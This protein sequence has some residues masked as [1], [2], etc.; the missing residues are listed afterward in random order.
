[1]TLYP[2]LLW[3]FRF[4]WAFSF[5]RWWWWRRWC[6]TSKDVFRCHVSRWVRRRQHLRDHYC[7]T[8]DPLRD[9]CIFHS[10]KGIHSK[11][12][13]QNTPRFFCTYALRSHSRH[14]IH[15]LHSKIQRNSILQFY[16]SGVSGIA[17][18]F[19]S[20][21]VL[22]TNWTLL[23]NFK[24]SKTPPVLKQPNHGH[25]NSWLDLFSPWRWYSL[26]SQKRP[27]AFITCSFADASP[28]SWVTSARRRIWSWTAR[29][30]T[31]AR[32]GR[33]IQGEE[34]EEAVWS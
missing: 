3:N 11:Y 27:P 8:T 17:F 18:G 7:A 6:P 4:R 26:L 1:M 5:W 24:I 34:E 32:R 23:H 12:C 2:P 9:K 22:T 14:M 10:K 15:A 13:W 19:D 21:W 31:W 28:G 33:R 30:S 16:Y 20:I 25:H 29:W